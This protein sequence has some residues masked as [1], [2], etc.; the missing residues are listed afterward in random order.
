VKHFEG[1][2]IFLLPSN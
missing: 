1:N 2:K